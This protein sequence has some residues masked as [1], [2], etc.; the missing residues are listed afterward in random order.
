MIKP[1]EI[2]GALGK[3]AGWLELWRDENGAYNGFIIHRSERKRMK[4]IHDTAW[5]QSAMIRGYVNLSR[6]SDQS[7]WYDAMV[8]AADLQASRFEKKSGKY[9]F[10]G[11]EDDRFCSLVHCALAN[12]ALL[13]AAELVEGDR[14]AEYIEIVRSNIEQYLIESLWVED[15]GAF[16]FSEEDHY[17][18][19]ED[20]YVIN[21]NCVAAECLL[22]LSELTGE[23]RYSEYAIRFGQWLI[24]RC[25]KARQQ[26]AQCLA[27]TKD[28]DKDVYV[29]AS[30]G[31]PYQYTS[32]NPLPDNCVSLYAG[33]ALRGIADLGRYTGEAEYRQIAAEALEFLN[34]M[35][36]D[37]THLFSHT[38]HGH[39]IIPYPQFIAGA[40]MALVGIDEA[41]DFLS[42][43]FD[44]ERTTR[45]ILDRTWT[46]GAA[47]S[48]IG[49]NASPRRNKRGQVWEDVAA[50]V[51]WNAQWFEYLTRIV[52]RPEEI[53]IEAPTTEIK[54]KTSRFCYEETKDDVKIISWWPW[55]SAGVFRLAKGS[56]KADICINV[57]G[58]I[59][60]S[61]HRLRD[62]LRSGQG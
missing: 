42:T 52:E 1:E 22:K 7:R 54:I 44:T 32:S 21:C 13:D 59:R 8:M 40:G 20:R 6:K 38:T 46:N 48:F 29:I 34:G 41:C 37:E 24:D 28:V 35:L 39:K 2:R 53:T 57:S 27:G 4:Y 5:T 61:Y 33:L 31:L 45:A 12:R 18:F 30:G 15:E 9:S 51:N 17:S 11:H 25:F 16:R 36:D 26:Y 19:D 50:S 62:L 14:R 10:A 56:A 55:E 49:K 43:E 3:L 60:S 58:A 23:Q 47:Q